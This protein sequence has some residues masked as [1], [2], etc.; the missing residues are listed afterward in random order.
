[1]GTPHEIVIPVPWPTLLPRSTATY[2]VTRSGRDF[3]G[4]ELD[5]AF[6]A[7][8]LLRVLHTSDPQ[9]TSA[10]RIDFLTGAERNVLGN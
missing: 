7:Q 10:G 3:G 2:A 6:A 5:T 4:Q 8:E 9:I 1:M